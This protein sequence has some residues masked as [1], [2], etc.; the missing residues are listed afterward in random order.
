M[1]SAMRS[2]AEGERLRDEGKTV[3]AIG[4]GDGDKT[5]EL[6]RS[7]LIGGSNS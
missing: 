2:A 3:V 5:I 1:M 7:G 4:W 6:N